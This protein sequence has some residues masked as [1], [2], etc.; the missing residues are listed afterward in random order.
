MLRS[1]KTMRHFGLP[2]LALC[3]S[4]FAPGAAKG[5][6]VDIAE[7]PEDRP[8]VDPV[9]SCRVVSAGVQLNWN[10]AFFAPIRGFLVVRD[11]ERIASLPAS[12]SSFLDAQVRPGEH[13]YE[14]FA[15]NLTELPDVGVDPNNA[16]TDS[17]IP[18]GACKVVV[19]PVDLGLRCKAEENRVH[20]EWG[21]ILIDIA[22]EGFRVE[23]NGVTIA[24]LKNNQLSYEDEVFSVGAHQYSVFMILTGG[25]IGPNGNVDNANS[26]EI[27]I[28]RCKVE[29]NCFGVRTRVDG[30]DVHLDWS[31]LPLPEI[32]SRFF[33]ITRDGE[34]V[35]K[36][37][38]TRFVDTVGGPGHYVYQIVMDFSDLRPPATIIAACRV[39]VPDPELLAPQNLR[40]AVA[41]PLEGDLVVDPNVGGDFDGAFVS[42]FW[43][44]P[45]EYDRLALTR[46]GE[47]LTTLPGDATHHND[48][49]PNGGAFVYGVYGIVGNRR[50]EAATCKVEVPPLVLP[51][52]RNLRCAVAIPDPQ[53]IPID[54]LTQI[55]ANDPAA[56]DTDND[57]IVDSILPF[58]VVRLSWENPIRY[59][60][61]IVTRNKA[62]VATL[63]GK[64]RSVIPK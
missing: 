3:G 1:R 26:N 36:T 7:R 62:I 4:L 46:N 28:G 23:R 55:D 38:D 17:L 5:Q 19:P 60:K 20:L 47:L 39:S 25:D 37:E 18:I 35:D 58:A 63:Q 50:S 45:V 59:D 49:P 9:L 6:I 21:P 33:T 43:E 27:L 2:V 57:G 53:P 24:R 11:D 29:V 61:I 22:F 13:Q 64:K 40:C 48:R 42:L 10:I 14:L 52:P 56:I 41:I 54:D 15:I 12:A 8:V 16:A 31:H 30:L 34:L 51:P 32:A 44:N